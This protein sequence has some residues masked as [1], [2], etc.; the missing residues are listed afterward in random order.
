M[1][2]NFKL[3]NL[4]LVVFLY[5]LV[6]FGALYSFCAFMYL[7]SYRKKKNRNFKTD[8]ITSFILLL[9]HEMPIKTF[10]EELVVEVKED[11]LERSHRLGKPKGKGNKPRLIIV[12]FTCY[13]RPLCPN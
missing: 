5:F 2:M 6:L 9:T 3:K 13:V 1:S 7:K 8:L 10:S 12:K 11:V 4:K